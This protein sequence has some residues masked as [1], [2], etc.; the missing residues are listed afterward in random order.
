MSTPVSTQVNK[1]T[2]RSANRKASTGS[3]GA[4][5]S[6]VFPSGP[7]KR[8]SSFE[9]LQ[10]EPLPKKM[11]DNQILDAING[12]K[13]SMA[14]MEQQLRTAPTKADINGLVSE[15]KGVKETVIRN[16]DRIDT[17]FDMR[18]TDSDFLAKHVDLSLIH[19]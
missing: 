19:I 18:K 8:K 13:S 12:I 6:P 11:A 16:T 5:A 10:D 4:G 9:P 17:L 15:I 2:T 3:G 7:R 14:A 1:P